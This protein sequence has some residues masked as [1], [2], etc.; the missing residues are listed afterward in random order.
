MPV[1]AGLAECGARSAVSRPS[2]AEPGSCSPARERAQKA[3]DRAG[4]RVGGIIRN[5]FHVSGRIMPEGLVAGDSREDILSQRLAHVSGKLAAP[6]RAL[7]RS[8]ADWE[9]ALLAG[10]MIA[11]AALQGRLIAAETAMRK[12]WK[13]AERSGSPADDLGIY[14][15]AAASTFD[16]IGPNENVLGTTHAFAART[17]R[18]PGNDESTGRH[19]HGTARMGSP[20]LCAVPVEDVHGAKARTISS[21]RASIETLWRGGA[22]AAPSSPTLGRWRGPWRSLY[23]MLRDRLPYPDPGTNHEVPQVIR[24]APGRPRQ[25]GRFGIPEPAGDDTLLVYREC[26]ER[27]D[28]GQLTT[29]YCMPW[30]QYSGRLS[31]RGDC[32]RVCWRTPA[33]S[34]D[35][36]DTR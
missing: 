4:I 11:E 14:R 13:P 19:R 29:A 35:H 27:C 8:P 36:L 32:R 5:S 7:S 10:L 34:I 24:T 1:R 31:P 17:S 20:H 9:R 33:L 6:C 21:S 26:P 22:A 12:R 25:F 16:E 2:L 28:A 15:L 18:S 3:I 23:V 30:Q